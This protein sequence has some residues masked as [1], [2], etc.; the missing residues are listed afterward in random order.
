MLA[1]LA[2]SGLGLFYMLKEQSSPTNVLSGKSY[3]VSA[4]ATD[5]SDEVNWKGIYDELTAAGV[6]GVVIKGTGSVRSLS[7]VATPK[8]AVVMQPGK[9]LFQ[10]AGGVVHVVLDDVREI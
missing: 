7:Y 8:Q 5:V 3:A 6:K 10:L 1:I 9:P 4:T 2:A